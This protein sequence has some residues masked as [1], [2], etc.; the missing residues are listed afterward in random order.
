MKKI[1]SKIIIISLINSLI[2]AIVNVSASLIMNSTRSTSD[3]AH[4]PGGG[5]LRG[6]IPPTT[7]LIGLG[8]SLVIGVIISYIL[9]RFI[10]AP[11]KM[12]T[13]ITKTT[14]K[15]D[16]VDNKAFDVTLKYKDESGDMAKAL[17]ETRKIL[18]EMVVKLQGIS[19]TVSS[20]S[21]N[22]TK[23]TDENV[24]T[25]SQVVATINELADGN[26]NQAQA[27]N[28]INSTMAEVVKLIENI[29]DEVSMGAENAVNSLESI[30]EGQNAVDMQSKKMDENI[31][32]SQEVNS[33]IK[34]LSKNVEQVA[35][36]INVI[37]SIADQ[38]NLLA[39]NAAIEA[40]RAGEAGKGFAVVADEIR[41]LAEESSN[42]ANKITEI[43]NN[44]TEKTSLSVA[45]ISK[46]ALIV[47]QQKEA[48]KINQEAFQK[49]KNSY[50]SIVDGFKNTA[51]AMKTVNDKSKEIFVQTQEVSAIAQ[52]SAAST[53][54]ISSAAEEELASIELIAESSKELDSLAEE[55]SSEI[56]KFKVS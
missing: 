43:I 48:L 53:E 40:A 23:V 29:T 20:H 7:E 9:G 27:V 49:I 1:S 51:A 24:K 28:A 39:L 15:L 42:A 19:S 44:T 32:I 37:T 8:I 12:I 11:L 31:T 46:A 47:E 17:A 22:L 14:A 33:S 3:G 45:N 34:E 56:Y 26:T 55:L 13:D 41:N 16:L 25:N 52:E 36:I 35:D 54:Q 5:G 18:R 4:A 50:D 30:T 6:I 38:T 21:A 10:S 2:V